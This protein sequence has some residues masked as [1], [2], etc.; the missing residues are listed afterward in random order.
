MGKIETEKGMST[1]RQNHG[2]IAPSTVKRGKKSVFM[3]HIQVKLKEVY[4]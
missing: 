4:K 1:I 3:I 2:Q